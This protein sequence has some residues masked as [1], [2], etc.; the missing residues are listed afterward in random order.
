[1]LSILVLGVVIS[2]HLVLTF[3]RSFCFGNGLNKHKS[4]DSI[5]LNNNVQRI[6][7]QAPKYQLSSEPVPQS[8]VPE[9]TSTVPGEMDGTDLFVLSPVDLFVW[10]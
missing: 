4:Q 8:S 3:L 5:N 10:F 2:V 1:M 9:F 6:A 7:P